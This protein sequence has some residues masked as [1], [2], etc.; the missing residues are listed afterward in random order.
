MLFYF[1]SI[2]QMTKLS[3]FNFSSVFQTPKLSNFEF[4]LQ[5]I[6]TNRK[7]TTII[8]MV[9][10]A[11][12][13]V[14]LTLYFTGVFSSKK[15][16]EVQP[17]PTPPPPPPTQPPKDQGKCSKITDSYKFKDYLDTTSLIGLSECTGL[18]SRDGKTK[19]ILHSNGELA[20]YVNGEKE[21]NVKPTQGTS[22]WSIREIQGLKTAGIYSN[23]MLV[24]ETLEPL[25]FNKEIPWVSLSDTNRIVKYNPTNKIIT[26]EVDLSS[27]DPIVNKH[28]ENFTL[29][30]KVFTLT[31]VYETN[32]DIEV[33]LNAVSPLKL[34]KYCIPQVI[35]LLYGPSIPDS[36]PLNLTF[37]FTNNPVIESMAYAL[38]SDMTYNNKALASTFKLYNNDL[39]KIKNEMIGVTM[40]ELTHIFQK[41]KYSSH[42][43]IEGIA[44]Y[45]RISTGF[46][47]DWSG[48]YPSLSKTFD[49]A[50]GT[51]PAYFLKWVT[52]MYPDFIIKLNKQFESSGDYNAVVKT[53]SNNK[54]STIDELWLDYQ[55]FLRL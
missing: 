12:T 54:Y 38:Y 15:S 21:Y 44:E 34:M 5:V 7:I 30:G 3:K 9:I 26:P 55:S 29:N 19:I 14:I 42:L 22:P 43:F 36:I 11:I 16:P 23:D 41:N 53:V 18:I 25:Y 1:I 28:S 45:V 24:K 27:T 2:L 32:P 47:A 4:T 49:T 48:E 33:I 35:Q 13:T 31:Y 40:H 51:I 50:Y 17:P 10:V 37:T 39:T 20:N 6:K 52:S 46:I 8:V